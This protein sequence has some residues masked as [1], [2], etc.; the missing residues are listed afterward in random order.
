MGSRASCIAA[1]LVLS[2]CL[3]GSCT[4][5]IQSAGSGTARPR[6]GRHCSSLGASIQVEVVPERR[7]GDASGWRFVGWS[8]AA[9]GA[10]NP[11]SSIRDGYDA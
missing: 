4:V 2:G 11:V 7:P 9:L 3:Q 6:A 10:A 8:E 1:L 5:D